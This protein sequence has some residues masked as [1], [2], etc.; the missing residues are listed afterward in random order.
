[1]W[2]FGGKDNDNNKLNDFWKLDLSSNMWEE[3]KPADGYLPLERSGHSCDLYE[4]YMIIFGG[5]YEI[6]K[7][8]NDLYLY[9]FKTNKW[10]TVFDEAVSPI[11]RD[12]SPSI[13]ED[14][15]P[16]YGLTNGTSP[17]KRTNI[18]P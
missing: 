12:M 6:T 11:K 16:I 4:N 13:N 8:L 5:I 9:D 3:V 15:S 2:V 18:S 7:E 1:M 10:V 17:K 14:I